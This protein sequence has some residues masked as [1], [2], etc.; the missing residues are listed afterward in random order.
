ME[1]IKNFWH[2]VSRGVP[3]GPKRSGSP[4]AMPARR[5]PH[6]FASAAKSGSQ[7]FKVIRELTEVRPE[8][9]RTQNIVVLKRIDFS[10]KS[11]VVVD[12]YRCSYAK[13]V[14]ANA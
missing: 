14:P 2:A 4:S 7:N 8:C 3:H 9:V 13:A 1:R 5:S 10:V 6:R 12:R 11:Q